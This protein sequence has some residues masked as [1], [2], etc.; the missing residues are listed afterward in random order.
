MKLYTILEK[1]DTF[2]IKNN[3]GYKIYYKGRFIGNCK[4]LE[5]FQG[6][7]VYKNDKEAKENEEINKMIVC[8]GALLVFS[9]GLNFS[10]HTI[11]AQE[12][13]EIV[14]EGKNGDIEEYK[15]CLCL[16]I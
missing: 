8:L 9:M 2:F 12:N 15:K 6:Y 7:R 13:I 11:Y 16:E 4:S 14:N 10:A 3:K 1:K 5:T